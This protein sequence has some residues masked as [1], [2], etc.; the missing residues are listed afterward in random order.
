MSTLAQPVLD[1][2]EFWFSD[3]DGGRA[4]KPSI[5]HGDLWSGNIASADGQPTVFD[6]ACYYGHAEAEWVRG[7]GWGWMECVGV[8]G[9]KGAAGV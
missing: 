3:L 9:K 4:V 2:L 8:V 1:N 7:D 6:P 5:L